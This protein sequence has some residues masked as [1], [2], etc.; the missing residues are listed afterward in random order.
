MS[1]FTDENA[2]PQGPRRTLQR[3]GLHAKVSI[4]HETC[5]KS[6]PSESRVLRNPENK[7]R[8]SV[9][10]RRR[11]AHIKAPH[12][13][14]LR[15]YL[16]CDHAFHPG[17]LAFSR[18]TRSAFFYVA[19]RREQVLTL[20]AV[21]AHALLLRDPMEVHFDCIFTAASIHRIP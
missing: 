16:T 15:A 12:R 4:I 2:S 6:M 19:W 9:S 14:A 1:L 21:L 7:T 10:T 20:Y 17:F 5:M 11:N 18:K 13:A 8:H 3:K